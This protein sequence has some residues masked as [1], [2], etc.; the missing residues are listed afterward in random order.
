MSVRLFTKDDF[1]K[2]LYYK[3][4]SYDEMAR[5]FILSDIDFLDL[6]RVKQFI[7]NYPEDG[8]GEA[9]KRLGMKIVLE[10]CHDVRRGEKLAGWLEEVPPSY[11]GEFIDGIVR[12]AHRLSVEEFQPFEKVLEDRFPNVFYE[13][14]GFSHLA[15]KYY[16]PLLNLQKIF[17]YMSSTERWVFKNFLAAFR[18]RV[19]G[20]NGNSEERKFLQEVEKTPSQYQ[21]DVVRGIGMRVGADMLSDPA[22]TVDYPLDSRFGEKFKTSNLQEAFYEGVGSGLAETLCRL[23]R[24]LLLPEDRKAPLYEKMLDI[25]WERCQTLMTRVA[26]LHSSLV[27][28]GFQAELKERRLPEGIKKYLQGKW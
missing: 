25:E 22:C 14:W 9:Y 5:R 11:L 12:K 10:L 3:G 1:K 17:N 20:H 2:T 24:T 4:Y 15:K 16:G 13:K 18:L 19:Q 28:K 6:Q 21:P 7:L 27:K 23:F 8:K 26:P